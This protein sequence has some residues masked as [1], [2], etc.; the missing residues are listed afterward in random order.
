MYGSGGSGVLGL[1]HCAKP[2]CLALEGGFGEAGW[3][4][5]PGHVLTLGSLGDDPLKTG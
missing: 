5:G 4:H 3:P 2:W 1:G